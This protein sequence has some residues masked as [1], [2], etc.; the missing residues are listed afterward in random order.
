M[1]ELP[2]D[3]WNSLNPELLH[4]ARCC[5]IEQLAAKKLLQRLALV[6]TY[7]NIYTPEAVRAF[8]AAQT[9]FSTQ[10]GMFLKQG[11]SLARKILEN[12]TSVHQN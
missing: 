8:E 12:E 10:I 6:K 5:N 9:H 7:I 11:V 3:A 1:F 2:V 4:N